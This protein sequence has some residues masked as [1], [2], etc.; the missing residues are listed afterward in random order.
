MI[1]SPVP[2]IV[3]LTV[4]A[5][6]Q[7]D[8][9]RLAA[10]EEAVTIDVTGVVGDAQS[11]APIANA[12]VALPEHGLRTVT[13]ERG[14]FALHVPVGEQRWLFRML[15]YADWEEDLELDD[16]EFLRVGLL[17][18]PIALENI[19]VTVDR[20]AS[21]RKMSSRSVHAIGWDEIRFS[22]GASA[23]EVMRSRS[24]SPARGCPVGSAPARQAPPPNHTARVTPTRTRA[25]P[26]GA[27]PDIGYCI[28]WRGQVVSP[29]IYMDDGLSPIPIDI[30]MAFAPHDIHT[31][32]FYDFGRY[33]LIY[34]VDF[35]RSGK[36]LLPLAA[37][38]RGR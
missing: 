22:A 26:G 33:V 17:P 18:Q 3:L 2:C 37:T 23:A 38:L 13:D 14:R 28:R 21:R 24:P 35:V 10:Q 36:P 16:G 15:G 12:V 20:L 29:I 4:L 5:T 7:V 30:V 34:T 25:P 27:N 32:E 11:G 1:R 19:T 31:I 8:A 6:L 9:D